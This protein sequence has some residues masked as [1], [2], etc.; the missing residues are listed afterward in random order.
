MDDFL[1]FKKMMSKA[2]M[3]LELEAVRSNRR[4]AGATSDE[5]SKVAVEEEPHEKVSIPF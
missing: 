2:N 5:I 1:T 3:E 4:K